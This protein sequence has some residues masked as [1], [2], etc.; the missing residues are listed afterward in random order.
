MKAVRFIER[1]RR[2]EG[3]RRTGLQRQSSIF[4]LARLRYDM[5]QHHRA[6]AFAQ[7]VCV[8]PHRLNLAMIGLKFLERATAGK[9]IAVPDRPE[10][11]IRRIQPLE[12]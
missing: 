6:R 10:G 11:D 9:A 3:L 1:Q 4:P 8:G 12:I 5:C 7:M 2:N